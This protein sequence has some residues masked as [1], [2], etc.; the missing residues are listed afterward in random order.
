MFM[1]SGTRAQSLYFRADGSIQGDV[2]YGP[3]G[4]A[5]LRHVNNND[6]TNTTTVTETDAT[7]QALPFETIRNGGEAN[8]TFVFDPG[9][10]LGIVQQFRGKG[11][12]HDTL[13]FKG[14]DFGNSIAEVLAHTHQY[15]GVGT[16]IGDPVSGDAVRITNISKAELAVNKADIAFHA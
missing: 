3:S 15:K 12:D 11:A 10:G 2:I 9:H 16:Y 6:G 13:S 4:S 8:N 1:S 14:A 7:V 5:A